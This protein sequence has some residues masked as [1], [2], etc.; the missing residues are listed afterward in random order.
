MLWQFWLHRRSG[1]GNSIDVTPFRLGLGA[2][3]LVAVHTELDLQA[4]NLPLSYNRLGFKIFNSCSGR[5]LCSM[6]CRLYCVFNGILFKTEC[7]LY[8]LPSLV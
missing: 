5:N 6:L 8:Y 3:D 7:V 2:P 4:L 1:T